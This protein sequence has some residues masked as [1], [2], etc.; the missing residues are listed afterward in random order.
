M[1]IQ[2]DERTPEQIKQN[3]LDRMPG[4]LDAREGSFLSD[5]IGPLALELW[6]DKE[7]RRAMESMFYVS[8]TSGPY[9]DKAAAVFGIVRKPGAKA[10]ALLELTGQDGTIIPKGKT[11]LAG[12]L[13]FIVLEQSVIENGRAQALAE[14]A[15]PGRQYNVEAGAIGQQYE[16][17]PGLTAVSSQA[18][19]GG[20]DE[21]TDQA[22]C[23]RYR[24]HL[25]NPATSGNK[26]HYRQWAL[27][28]DGVG[29]AAV[30]PQ[31]EGP[32][33]VG[34][35]LADPE[36]RPASQQVA[37]ACASHIEALRPVGASVIVQPAQALVVDI[38]ARLRLETSTTLE[39]VKERF[40]ADLAAYFSQSAFSKRQL[41]Y[42]RVAYMLLNIP[43][44]ADY[45]QL[46]VCGEQQDIQ[47]GETQAPTIGEV[48]FTLETD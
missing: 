40:A 42:H 34:V 9:L 20:I 25:Q 24:E 36:G 3:I 31:M 16:N 33:T 7:S 17:L 21:E 12:S 48:E 44:V 2:L 38:S 13:E 45:R 39:R 28:V 32:G 29:H 43:G 15:Q 26:A 46:T 22:L 47:I 19:V 37:E 35:I 11:F 18:A 27:E 30:I 6:K 1:P 5:M 23:L 14:A 41:V 4:S 8:E 10:R